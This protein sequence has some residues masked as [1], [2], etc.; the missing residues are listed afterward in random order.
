VSDWGSR[1]YGDPCRGCG[2]EWAIVTQDA[3]RVI[4]AAP[5]AYAAL[6]ADATGA[7]KAPGLDWNVT[8]YVAHVADNLRI[9]AERLAAA[10][11]T[12][13]LVVTRYDE[14]ALAVARRYVELPLVGT[15]WSLRE[16]VEEW[17]RAWKLTEAPRELLH[18]ER[19]RIR[20][21]EVAV[22]NA[23]DVI[24]HKWDIARCLG[25]P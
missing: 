9:W 18:S 25:S 22:T 21:D 7:E 13:P 15:L 16:A 5:E 23:H 14:N 1:T 17:H 10:V 4:Q 19:G 8:A 12:R 11:G 24:H 6:V 20:A 3:V 2:F